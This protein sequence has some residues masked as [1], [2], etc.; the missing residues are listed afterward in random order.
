MKINEHRK[1]EKTTN[2]NIKKILEK[3]D[4]LIYR[5]VNFSKRTFRSKYYPNILTENINFFAFDTCIFCQEIINLEIIS[6]KL[7]EMNR[8]LTWTNC[9]KCKNPI[10]PKLTVHF[11]KEIN[12]NGDM[13]TNTSN[14]DTVVLFSPYFL[15][16]NYNTSFSR[17][18]CVKLDVDELMM[19]YA[20]IY[21]N[22]LWYFK[23]NKLEYD[24][25]QPYYYR[26]EEI[27]RSLDLE[28][29]FSDD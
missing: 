9:P 2:D 7:K 26:L 13:K 24:F 20:P 16:N 27:K 18:D 28:V 5:K 3:E 22:S 10:L 23:L 14:Y 8:D 15:K 1:V 29:A 25:M 21:W 17:K 12:K 4:K 11:G 6:K 19:K